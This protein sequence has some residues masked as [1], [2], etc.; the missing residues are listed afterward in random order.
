MTKTERVQFVDF[1]MIRSVPMSPVEKALI[2]YIAS[3]S[4][5]C[6][7]KTIEMIGKSVNRSDRTIRRAINSLCARGLIKKTYRCFKRVRLQLVSRKA[8]RE[9]MKA[10]VMIGNMLRQVSKKTR[11]KYYRSSVSE[12][13]RSSVSEPNREENQ[14]NKTKNK[15]GFF[16]SFK[17]DFEQERQR[18][19]NALFQ[20]L[21]AKH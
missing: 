6:A 1:E 16:Q 11:E 10:G 12:L 21:A 5:C 18:Q 2:G 4:E 9:L 7:P 13:N 19:L 17:I 20:S 3:F 8:Q 14:K 15:D